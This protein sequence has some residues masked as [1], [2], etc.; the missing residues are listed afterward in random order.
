M[1]TIYGVVHVPA[2]PGDPHGTTFEE[3]YSNSMRDAEA[4]AAGGVHGIIIENFGSIPFVKGDASN[5]L[6]P[7]QVAAL[8]RIATR[9]KS[10]LGIE[11][12][13]NCLRND[14][15]SAMGIAA[16]CELDFI[17]VNVHVGAAVTDQ[18]LIEG[19]A[20]MTLRYRR[21]LGCRAKI[22]ADVL[23]KHASPLGT[24][25]PHEATRD[26]VHR[27]LADAVIVSGSG[28]GEPVNIERLRTVRLAAAS[29]PVYV[30]SGLVPELLDEVLPHV[31]GGIVGTWFKRAAITRNPVDVARVKE[32]MQE[33]ANWK[34]P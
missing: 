22:F 25:D 17:R 19:E 30:G 16:A 15:Y 3:A 14:A 6:P 32:F 10:T 29:V 5:R 18:G 23:V 1:K 12:G 33:I 20:H 28:T 9:C 4:L 7:H 13:V 2:L 24:S 11:V 27:G 34:S 8:T 31:S 26:C 21:E